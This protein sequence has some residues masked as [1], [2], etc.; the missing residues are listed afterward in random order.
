[1]PYVVEA[2]GVFLIAYSFLIARRTKLSERR[3][4]A[5]K[6]SIDK[7][8]KEVNGAIVSWRKRREKQLEIKI[9]KGSSI[10]IIGIVVHA[11]C[12]GLI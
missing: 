12:A 2:I 3:K 9:L 10:L 7:A 1:M 5:P 11:A 6:V 8:K 4:P